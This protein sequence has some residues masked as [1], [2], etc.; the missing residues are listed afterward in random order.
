MVCQIKDIL[1]KPANNQHNIS[2]LFADFH[3]FE[4]ALMTSMNP[5][6]VKTEN[7]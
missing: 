4:K 3:K 5:E 1:R 7:I 6:I 2:T